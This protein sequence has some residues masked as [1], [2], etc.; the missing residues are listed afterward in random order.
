MR[1]ITRRLTAAEC[2]ARRTGRGGVLLVSQDWQDANLFYGA[3]D[4]QYT[5]E[6]LRRIAASGRR[7]VALVY[8]DQSEP[9]FTD[10]A[11]VAMFDE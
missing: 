10:G 9:I 1:Q 2:K 8:D 7:V 11:R 3:G 6:D 5:A 4:A